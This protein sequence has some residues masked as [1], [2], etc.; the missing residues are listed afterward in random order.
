MGIL[1]PESIVNE[2]QSKQEEE[3]QDMRRLCIT[4]I[5]KSLGLKDIIGNGPE[6]FAYAASKTFSRL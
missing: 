5:N 3:E 1:S 4:E 2:E 6:L